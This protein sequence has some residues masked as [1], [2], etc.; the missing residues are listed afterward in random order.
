MKQIPAVLFFLVIALQAYSKGYHYAYNKNCSSAYTAYL[1][2]RPEEGKEFL[3]KELIADPYNLMATYIADYNDC[4]LLLFNGDKRDYAQ[5]KQH[6]NTRLA[7]MN[8]GDDNSPWHRLCK[9]GLHMHW[10]FVYLRFNEQ[11]KAAYNFRK[12]Y[13]LLKENKRMFPDFAYTD[14]FLGIEDATIGSIPDNYKW[15]ASLFGMKGDLK[16]GVGT[17]K[18]FIESHKEGDAF[19]AE[20]LVYYAYM[21]YYLLSDK[22]EAWQT[23]NRPD[24]STDKNLVNAFVKVNLAINY[25]KAGEAERLL[26]QLKGQSGYNSFPIFNYEYGYALMHKLD[27]NAIGKF[28]A[29]LRDYKGR[30]FVQDA[31]QKMAYMHHLS[32][33]KAEAEYCKKKI[34]S[35]EDPITDSDK[36]AIR[37]AQKSTWPNKS[38]LQAQL[39]TDGGYYAEAMTLLNTH[40]SG[41][42]VS[43]ADKLE[44][45]FRLARAN[46]ESGNINTAVENYKK[47]IGIGR[48]REEQFAA[49][50][51]LQLGFLY[52]KQG[53]NDK[54]M[55]MYKD[56]LSMKNHDFQNSID[57]QA[58]AGINRLSAH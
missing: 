43:I 16:R 33:K 15:L 54:A 8:R 11:F 6:L 36:Q 23:V 1:S 30:I 34:L 17:V 50:A 10:A 31:W 13:I 7:L 52:E 9:A 25:R 55:M 46:D 57:Q 27:T 38:L 20:A 32:G 19:Y 39:L 35:F 53:Q 45:H 22:S 49:R 26:K 2:L 14:I 42:Y 29:F 37:F 40:S 18:K 58:K 51:A 21:N 56:A 24:F 41:D 3:K 48:Q 5:L 44:Y 12:S 47:A 28:Q 4:L